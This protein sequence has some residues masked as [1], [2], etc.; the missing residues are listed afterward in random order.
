MQCNFPRRIQTGFPSAFNPVPVSFAEPTSCLLCRGERAAARRSVVGTSKKVHLQVTR[1]RVG[2]KNI[3]LIDSLNPC[4]FD[5]I[6][7]FHLAPTAYA[8]AKLLS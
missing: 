1:D 4:F 6:L 2:Y 3:G 5:S 7:K 8:V